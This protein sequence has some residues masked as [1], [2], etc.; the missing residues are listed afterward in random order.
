LVSVSC[1][2]RPH[3]AFSFTDVLC[4]ITKFPRQPFSP[5]EL[6]FSLFFL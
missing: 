2:I 6:Y 5:P 1:K 3:A 4:F